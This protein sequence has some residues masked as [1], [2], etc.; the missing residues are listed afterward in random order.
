MTE[1]WHTHPERRMAVK[2]VSII[3]GYS[4]PSIYEQVRRGVFPQPFQMGANASRW[5]Y[6]DVLEWMQAKARG[7]AEPVLPAGRKR[8]GRPKAAA[9]SNRQPSASA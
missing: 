2:E 9:A 8:V 1:N 3:T 7:T 5:R 4:V 6:A